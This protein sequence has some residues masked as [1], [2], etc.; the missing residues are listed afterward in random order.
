M[1]HISIQFSFISKIAIIN[2]FKKVT[3]DILMHREKY[4]ILAGNWKLARK[5]KIE[6]K[7]VL[8]FKEIFL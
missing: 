5:N 6:I 8:L 2:F 1:S 4:Q 7:Y 3:R